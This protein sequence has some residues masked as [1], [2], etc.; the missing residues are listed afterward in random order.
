MIRMLLVVFSL[1]FALSCF[2]GGQEG[3]GEEAE[4]SPAKADHGDMTDLEWAN[5]FFISQIYDAHWN[6][7]GV[8]TDTGS[9]ACGPASLAMMMR[10][11]D[12]MP[13]GLTA[14][15]AIDHARALMYP[16]YPDIHEAEL[17]DGA[18]LYTEDDLVFVD[19]DAHPV[20]FDMME[21][22]PSVPQGIEHGGGEVEFGYSWSE[23]DALAEPG[24]A[25]IAYGHIT[26]DWR[27]RFSGHYGVFDPGGVPH[28]IVVFSASTPKDY[29]VCDP[30]HT[31]GAVVMSR[32][33]LQTFFKSPVSEYD[34]TIRLIAWNDIS[35]SHQQDVSTETREEF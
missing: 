22:E 20:Y 31:G 32:N 9:N 2:G 34:T 17:P 15:K 27:N 7:T 24:G 12:L 6:S 5:Q 33:E 14:Q 25:V 3:T 1:F 8:E 4:P 30:M 18:I 10:E 23:L 16:D 21:D 11:R 35:D 26:E 19:D 13:T 28:F 29:I